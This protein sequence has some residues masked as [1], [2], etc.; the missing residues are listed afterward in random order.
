MRQL[1]RRNPRRHGQAGRSVA[2]DAAIFGPGGDRKSFQMNGGRSRSLSAS[3]AILLNKQSASDPRRSVGHESV[4][5]SGTALN[6]VDSESA[7]YTP[8]NGRAVSAFSYLPGSS[9]TGG[10]GGSTAAGIVNLKNAEAADPYYRPPRARRLTADAYTSGPASRGSW[11]SG[12]WANRRWSQHSPANEGSPNHVEGLPVSGR[13]TPVPAHLGASR[14]RSDSNAE[15]PRRSKTDYATREVDFYYGVRGPALSNLPTRRLKTGPADPTGSVSSATGWLKGLFGGKTKDTGKGFEVVRSSR[16]PQPRSRTPSGA[17]VLDE[18]IPYTDDPRPTAERSRDLALSD[19]GDAIGSGTRRLPEEDQPSALGSDDDHDNGRTPSEDDFS[20]NNRESQLSPFPPS[21]PT[22]ETGGGIE[23]PS[24]MASTTSSTPTRDNTR[25][26]RRPPNVPRRS[27]RRQSQHGDLRYAGSEGVQL[28]TISPSPQPSPQRTARVYDPDQPGQ[29]RL[30]P[31]D[32]TT[33]RLPFESHLDASQDGRLS[34]GA[35]SSTKSSL[36]IPTDDGSPEEAAS[37][38]RLSSSVLGSLAPDLR[39]DRP[40]SMGYVQQHRASDNIHTAS[41]DDPPYL[42]SSAE[43]VN[44][45]SQRSVS[46]DAR[47]RFP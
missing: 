12:D 10:E 32:A 33:N 40:Q 16:A 9:Q 21:L 19:E 30:K 41:P 1:S 8:S 18:N 5:A 27:S 24:R 46:P 44:D 14:E 23:L 7:P 13:G 4:S 47:P 11:N 22:I 26:R 15:D 20:P 38:A 36:L 39:Q 29:R 31:P 6:Q 28:S 37:H 17:L 2:S 45:P 35:E 42:G 34:A 43:V 25:D 3:S